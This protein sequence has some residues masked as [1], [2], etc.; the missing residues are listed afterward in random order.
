MNFKVFAS[1]LWSSR[2]VAVGGKRFSVAVTQVW[3]CIVLGHG[4]SLTERTRSWSR[5]RWVWPND[6][7]RQDF[8]VESACH[9]LMEGACGLKFVVRHSVLSACLSCFSASLR[10]DLCA[11][12]VCRRSGWGWRFSAYFTDS[13]RFNEW[14]CCDLRMSCLIVCMFYRK[15]IIIMYSYFTCIPEF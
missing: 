14:C 8:P 10:W 6:Y 11:G 2:L 4:F 1:R 7:K 5:S 9:S 12:T 15:R 3:H 13:L